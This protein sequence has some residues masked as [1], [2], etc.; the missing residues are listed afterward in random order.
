M[1]AG[2]LDCSRRIGKG[3]SVRIGATVLSATTG[4]EIATPNAARVATIERSANFGAR[5]WVYQK[6]RSK[7]RGVPVISAAIG[8]GIP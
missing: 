7:W 5:S 2:D 4:A 3:P 6:A 1:T 8:A